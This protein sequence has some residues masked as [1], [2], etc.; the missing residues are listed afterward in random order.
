VNLATRACIDGALDFGRSSRYNLRYL[1]KEFMILHRYAVDI[2]VDVTRTDFN[3]NAAASGSGFYGVYQEHHKRAVDKSEALFKLL[4]PWQK[5]DFRTKLAEKWE[6]TYNMK[7][8]SPEFQRLSKQYEDLA[9]L[10]G[11]YGK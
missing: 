2:A 9:K 1:K 5:G 11:V 7:I 6:K 3:R 10:Q 8:G 4:M